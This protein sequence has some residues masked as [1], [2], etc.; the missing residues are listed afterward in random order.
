VRTSISLAA[1]LVTALIASLATAAIPLSKQ[2]K[3]LFAYAKCMRKKGVNIPDPVKGKNGAYAFPTIP[4]SI[5]NAPGVRTKAQACSR[6]AG[7]ASTARRPQRPTFTAA[8][9]KKLQQFQACL[10][11]HGVTRT[12]GGPGL[13]APPNRAPS[14]G[15]TPPSGQT[16]PADFQPP[17]LDAKTQKAMTACQKYSPFPAGGPGGFGGAPPS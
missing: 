9:Q 15:Q 6:A 3:A 8:Q 12:F 2:D 5:T 4:T 11:K 16:P 14:N 13:G 1:I 10:K 7:F 17:K